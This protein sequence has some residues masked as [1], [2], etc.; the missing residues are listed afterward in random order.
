MA[1]ACE[2]SGVMVSIVS[3]LGPGC[4]ES[5][6]TYIQC[7]SQTSCEELLEAESPQRACAEELEAMRQACEESTRQNGQ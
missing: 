5:A 4:E 6:R 7:V 2:A 3:V 1:R